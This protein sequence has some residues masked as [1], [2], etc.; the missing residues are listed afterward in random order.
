MEFDF[1]REPGRVKL[2]RELIQPENPL[3]SIVTPYY[4]AGEYFIQ[5]YNCV[6]NQTF[7]W[8]EWVIVDDGSTVQEDIEL[9]DKLSSADTRIKVF[10]QENK[11]VSSARNKGIRQASSEIIVPLDSDDLITPTYLELLYWAL[12]YNVDCAW[13]YT[14]SL[15]FQNQEYVWEKTFSIKTLKKDNFLT[16]TAAIRKKDILEAGLYDESEKYAYEDWRL[17]L[18]LLA[19]GKK[20]VKVC[21]KGF[22]YRRIEGGVSSIVRED[23]KKKKKALKKIKEIA[24]TVSDDIE[25]RVFPIASPINE[26]VKPKVSSWKDSVFQ[27]K[28][29]I[30]IMMLLPWMVMGG[31]DMFNLE[32]VKGLS[33][34]HYELSAIL[35]EHSPNDWRQ[36]FEEYITDIFELPT[37]LEVKNYAEFVSYF[38]ISR[39]I[40]VIFLSNSYYGYYIVPWIRKEFPDVVVVDYVHMEEWYW[41]N[42]GFARTSGN[43]QNIIDR[44]FVCNNGTQQ[45]LERNFGRSLESVE[46]LYIGVDKDK[47][48]ASAYSYGAVKMRHGIDKYRPLI[49]FPCRIHPQKRPF[50][51]FEIAQKLKKIVPD[52]AFLVVGD[53][54]LLSELKAKV[55]Q[56][57]LVHTIYFAGRQDEMQP[58]Y[59]DSFATLICSIK[60][61]LAL[62]AYES[63]SMGV[64]VITSDV[65]GQAEL[66]DKT[67]GIVLPLLQSEGQDYNYSVYDEKEIQQYVKAIDHLLKDKKTYEQMCINCRK[68]VEADF[69]TEVMIQKLDGRIQE[70][71]QDVVMV[72]E[73]KRR[74]EA[75]R[76]ID[77]IID[78][79]LTV[80]Q[81]VANVDSMFK[82]GYSLGTKSELMRIANS[83]WGKRIIKV[84]LKL[85]LNKIFR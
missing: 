22:W 5:T 78:D 7:P 54:P 52:I 2:D 26:Y 39:Q 31:A 33:K 55:K 65:G 64:P 14:D 47:F 40:D 45:V 66:I 3:V 71:I 60:E 56:A 41:R 21:E 50:L 82:E 27:K 20:P 35:T 68:R 46:T 83:Q 16:L 32:V 8:F 79:Y 51:M 15:G 36:R 80:Y 58:Y 72:K 84:V 9:L 17:W 73:R 6:E 53:G 76:K 19:L 62:T 74:A 75:L 70:L 42:G 11:G 10:R 18:Q 30:H 69:S 24:G 25:A 49:L 13:A 59:R 23:A 61:G 63:C 29:K 48:D 1:S 37:F 12:Y 4:N 85:K 28:D 44:T 81:E 38:I 57:D 77:A 34:E 67:S 43:M